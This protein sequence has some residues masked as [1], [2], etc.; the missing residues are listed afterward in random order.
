MRGFTL[1]EVI[2]YLALFALLMSGFLVASFS[3][4]ES[5]GKDTTHSMVEAE[6]EYLLAKINWALANGGTQIDPT[7]LVSSNMQLSNLSFY[8][9]PG[10]GSVGVRFTL[11]MPSLEGSVVS[12][13]FFSTTTI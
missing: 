10:A 13:D 6:G 5:S 8:T 2:I 3:L 7:A 11:A 1:I 4:I 9:A 12:E